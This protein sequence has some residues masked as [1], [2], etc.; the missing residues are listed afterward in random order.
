MSHRPVALVTG[1]GRGIGLAIAEALAPHADLCLCARSA[2]QLS[3]AVESLRHR[4]KVVGV[5]ADVSVRADVEQL[6]A[7]CREQLG[8][9]DWLVNNA[10]VAELATLETMTDAQ[11]NQTL[12]VNL[13]GVFLCAQLALPDLAAR[14]GRIVNIGSISGTLG[15]PR[16]SA[17]NASKWGVNGLTKAWAAELK[18]RGVS[19]TAVLPGSV[20][21]EMLRKS[22]FPPDMMPADIANIVRYLC[23][24]APFAMTGALVEAFG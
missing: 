23:L 6:V 9:V 19:V 24:E 21:T 17:Y 15:T 8:P 16:M 4:T 2:D 10:G 3:A 18:A 12:D 5:V 14:R 1:A 13:K 7:R 11:W 22:G 20:D